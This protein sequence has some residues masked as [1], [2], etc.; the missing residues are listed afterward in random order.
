MKASYIN[1]FTAGRDPD[2]VKF[3][4]TMKNRKEYK[5][6]NRQEMRHLLEWFDECIDRLK[7]AKKEVEEDFNL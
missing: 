7:K 2:I 1:I 5:K 6:L 4:I 3:E